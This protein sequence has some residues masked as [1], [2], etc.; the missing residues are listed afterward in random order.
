MSTRLAAWK[1]AAKLQVNEYGRPIDLSSPFAS[2]LIS[3]T[4][5]ARV[6]EQLLNLDQFGPQGT[7]QQ[8]K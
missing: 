6:A 3:P 5:I 4:G 1:I 2:H 8:A 7:E